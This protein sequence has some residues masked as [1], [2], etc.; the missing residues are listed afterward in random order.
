MKILHPT[1]FIVLSTIDEDHS[2]TDGSITNVSS[3]SSFHERPVSIWNDM[4]SDELVML[5]YEHCV[6]TFALE[7]ALLNSA[8]SNF[9]IV[10]ALLMNQFKTTRMNYNPCT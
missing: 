1:S 10:H 4:G 3:I 7:D 8:N 5:L 9:N 6:S 2:L